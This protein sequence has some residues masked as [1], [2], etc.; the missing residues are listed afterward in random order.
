MHT[1][2]KWRKQ[3]LGASVSI[4][5]VRHGVPRS[6]V[7]KRVHAPF[8]MKI[9]A[10]MN[11]LCRHATE[12]VFPCTVTGI[13]R[14]EQI[15][16]V[17]SHWSTPS[18]TGGSSK[19]K[20]HQVTTCKL[21]RKGDEITLGIRLFYVLYLLCSIIDSHWRTNK[22][23]VACKLKRMDWWSCMMTMMLTILQ[24][25]KVGTWRQEGNRQ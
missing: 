8:K 4:H 9:L 16:S 17:Q 13:I 25:V 1:A 3:H 22:L 24:G 2:S 21:I 15:P 23:C 6:I 7:H 10:S 19:H 5:R 12:S 14:N 18:L 11:I 20:L